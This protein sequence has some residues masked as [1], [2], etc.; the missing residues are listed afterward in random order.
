MSFLAMPAWQAWLL[1]AAVGALCHPAD[2][3][4][5]QEARPTMQNQ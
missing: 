3:L 4:A 1:V 5:G 2:I